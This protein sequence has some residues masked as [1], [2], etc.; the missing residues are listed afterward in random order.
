MVK[1]GGGI[2]KRVLG[3]Y[4]GLPKGVY[5]IFFGKIITCIGAFVHPLMALI[6]TDKIG[7]SIS[8]A[9]LMIST[10]ALVQ[11]PSI[12]LGG[13]LADRIG[14]KKTI[15]IFQGLGF[16][17][18]TIC[19]FIGTS[20]YLAYL[21]IIASAFFS[22]AGPSLDALTADLTTEE[23]RK[24]SYSLIYLGVNL[25]YAIGP[26]LGGL[27]YTNHLS[28]IFLG[29]AIT[30]L[31]SMILILKFVDEPDKEKIKE[32]T[33][34]T[35]VKAEEGSVF[36]IIFSRPYL[37]VFAIAMLVFQFGYSQVGFAIPLHLNETFNEM[38]VQYFGMLS[39]INA[40]SVVVLTPLIIYFTEKKNSVILMAIGGFLYAVAFLIL[41][42]ANI[43]PIFIISIFVLTIGEVFISI[44]A[45]AFVANTT[46]VSHRGRV[47]GI[48]P[49]IYGAGYSIGPAIMGIILEQNTMSFAWI[50]ISITVAIGA[51]VMY[52][53]KIL[54][55][56]Q[57]KE[58]I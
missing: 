32:E 36:K 43:L 19:S 24:A 49:L 11:A 4:K 15:F 41:S 40:V 21:M 30:T 31:C 33:E 14:R 26:I 51:G 37:I 1:F 57:V 53:N 16:I 9:G 5:I 20:I 10:L 50:L 44:N 39:A 35:F 3:T 34:D 22:A 17:A 54:V 38:G 29:D 56:K 12:I 28:I 47:S 42:A 48:L 27:L 23:N 2:M 6:L 18:F 52:F 45:G 8:D 55:Q 25:G 58:N 7:M 13:Q 46:P